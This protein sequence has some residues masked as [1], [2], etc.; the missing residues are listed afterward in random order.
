MKMHTFRV[1]LEEPA[2]A[3]HEKHEKPCPLTRPNEVWSAKEGA[4]G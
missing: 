3:K 2:K 4:S 1:L